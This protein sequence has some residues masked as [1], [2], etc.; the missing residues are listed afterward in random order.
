MSANQSPPYL[1]DEQIIVA[2]VNIAALAI[3]RLI[4]M[5][6]LDPSKITSRKKLLPILEKL[7]RT[8][9]DA[10]EIHIERVSQKLIS[11]RTCSRDG[12]AE[13]A[14][15]LLY[16]L[17]EGEVN[18]AIR[19]LLRIR[20]FSHSAISDALRGTDIKS[21]LQVVLPL[22]GVDPGARIRQLALESQ[23]MRNASIH[24]KAQ[25]DVSLTQTLAK[26]ITAQFT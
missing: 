20:G 7:G 12:D 10:F 3:A 18:T 1:V 8:H 5:K 13:S 22:L 4:G 11:I 17:I 9:D 6:K 26:A 24:Y 21:K 23:G 19:I 14:V 2:V 15:I 25:P 16:T